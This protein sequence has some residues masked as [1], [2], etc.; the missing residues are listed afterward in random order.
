MSVGKCVKRIVPQ[1]KKENEVQWTILTVR[2]P[3]TISFI[4]R[5]SVKTHGTMG[6]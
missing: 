4:E 2:L 6:L 3:E 1:K 5:E